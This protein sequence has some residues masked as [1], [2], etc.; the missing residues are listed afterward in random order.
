MTRKVKE[1]HKVS[2]LIN[3]S[4]MLLKLI[5]AEALLRKVEKLTKVMKVAA[6]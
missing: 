4:N 6:S 3:Q 2:N 1:G 5:G